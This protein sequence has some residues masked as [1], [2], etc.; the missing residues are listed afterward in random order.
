M[1]RSRLRLP[2]LAFGA[3][4][5]AVLAASCGGGKKSSGGT[6][7]TT[8]NISGSVSVWGIWVGQEQKNFQ[9][10]IDA[11]KKQYPNVKVT[12]SP[13][14]NNLPTIL[15]T[16]VQGGKPPDVA[17]P[18]Q[19]G[20]VEQF[21]TQGKLKPIAYVKGAVATNF[22]NSIVTAGTFEKKFYALTYKADNKSTVFYNVQAYK[23]AGVTPATD[24]NTF[25]KD[26]NTIKASGLPAYA[27]S[28]ADGWTLTDLFENIY[29]RTAGPQKYDQLTKHQIPWT[30]SSVKTALTDMAQILSD[31]S[32][33]YGG[34]NGALQTDFPTAVGYVL[35]TKA[36]AAQ[37]IEG[38]FVPAQLTTV[39]IKPVTG[40]NEFTFPAINGSPS[41]VVGA[42]N[43]VITFNDNPA[44]EAFV[45][46]LATPAA[47]LPWIRAGGFVSANKHVAASAYT[48]PILRKAAQDLTH[49]TTFKFDMSDQAPIAFGGTTG[50]G[51]WK[52]LQ[53]FLKNPSNVNGTAQS[54]ETAAAKA[55]KSS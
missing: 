11:F 40:Y 53:D 46:F 14:G 43:L 4:A 12:Y 31:S 8:S 21:V 44:I 26:G 42:G 54:L 38:D 37:V 39:P 32:N 55:Y 7:T 10:V 50:Q 24:W 36:K 1:T 48:D 15:T 51:E 3:L 35:A 34:T 5:I 27:I 17:A 41:A 13:K 52:I 22:G 30:D 29:L 45:K 47:A 28:G 33:M 25:I 23:S 6:T 16:A 18:A 9:A 19:P 49:A 20:L 2:M